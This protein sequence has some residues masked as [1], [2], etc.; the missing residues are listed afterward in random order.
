M[1]EQPVREPKPSY[2]REPS[3]YPGGVQEPGGLVPPYEGRQ[4]EGPRQDEEAGDTTQRS[5]A[6]GPRE[7]S[8]AE[9]EGVSPTDTTAASPHGVGVSTSTQGNVRMHG[10][11][12]E[13]QKADQLD[14]GTD[15]LTPNIDPESPTMIRGDQ[16][17]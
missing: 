14:A 8:Q 10:S 11:S 15:D 13:A 2:P 17:G 6:A 12:T 4:T 1:S 3:A 16:G 7:V 9:R 5:A